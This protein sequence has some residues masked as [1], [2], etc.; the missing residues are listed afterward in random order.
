M[1]RDRDADPRHRRDRPGGGPDAARTS[2]PGERVLL[3]FGGSQAV[4]RFNAAVAEALPRLVERV[5]VIHVTGEDGYAAALAG[6]E[7]LPA[8][9]RAT[10]TGRTRSCATRCWPALAAADLVVGRAGSSTLAEVTALGLPM[11]VVPYPHAAGHQRANAASLVEAGAARLDRRRGLRRRRRSLEAA[12]L[13]DDPAGA[14]R[15]V[16]RRPRARPAGRGRRGRRARAGRRRR[17]GRCPDAGRD[18]APRPRRRGD[19]RAA[20]DAIATGTDIQR[21]IGVKTSRD[22][23]LARFTTMRVG[24]PADL[25]A[26][27]HNVFELRAL[28]RFAR[29]REL[30]HIVLGR[31]SDV[32]IADAGD[33]RPGHPGPRRGLAGR[34]RRAT[35][36]RRACRWRG[37]RPRPSRPA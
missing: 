2:P 23:P 26:T 33:P 20:F 18:R 21:R 6:R 14:R 7:A 16:G 29:A 17:A 37:P 36:P 31:G 4:R 15:D 10:A 25:F 30:P 11:V 12:G 32:V 28:V 22:E 35:R 34:R 24:G 19:D 13:L 9:V 8:E 3:I 5:T 27:V 1:L